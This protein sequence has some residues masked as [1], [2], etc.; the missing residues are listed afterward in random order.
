MAC[1]RTGKSSVAKEFPHANRKVPAV[2]AV[3]TAFENRK[4]Q[5]MPRLSS[6]IGYGKSMGRPAV[7]SSCFHKISILPFEARLKPA[8][9]RLSSPLPLF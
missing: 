2:G 5:R 3:K 4:A 6:R 9:S 8:L 1:F 7:K